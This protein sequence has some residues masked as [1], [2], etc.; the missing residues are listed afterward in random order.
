MNINA[1]SPKLGICDTYDTGYV[2]R[3]QMDAVRVVRVELKVQVGVSTLPED[4]P[5][6][7]FSERRSSNECRERGLSAVSSGCNIPAGWV[8]VDQADMTNP[9]Q[10]MQ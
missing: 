5:M 6:C 2:D 1:L 7:I 10:P 4:V 8:T 9:L 3:E